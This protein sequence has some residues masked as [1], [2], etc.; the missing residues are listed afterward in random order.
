MFSHK[1]IEDGI[2][3]PVTDRVYSNNG[4]PALIDLLGKGCNRLSSCQ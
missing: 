4:N 1:I 2:T 3:Y